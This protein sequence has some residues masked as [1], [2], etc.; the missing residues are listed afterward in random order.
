MPDSVFQE[1]GLVPEIEHFANGERRFRLKSAAGD[2]YVRTEAGRKGGWQTSHYHT[3]SHETYIVQKGW[4]ALAEL[5]DDRLRLR[6]VHPGEVVTTELG[7]VHNVYL[8][9]EA[10]IHTV[11]HG[12]AGD[13]DWHVHKA[14]DR[15][16]MVLDEA[17]ILGMAPVEPHANHG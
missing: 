16:T 17:E 14:F 15:Q 4:M 9:A 2:G 6:T 7:V 10:I 1:H 13:D 3:R 8:P 12:S 11:K 5:V